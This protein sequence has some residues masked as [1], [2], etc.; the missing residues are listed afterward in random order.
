MGLKLTLQD[1]VI[2]I[3]LIVAAAII[4]KLFSSFIIILIIGLVGFF[5]YKIYV[6]KKKVNNRI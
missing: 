4:I 3:V 6:Q 1:Y 5:I 2:I